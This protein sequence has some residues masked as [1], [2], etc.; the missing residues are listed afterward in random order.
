ME[1]N[2]YSELQFALD[3]PLYS[4]A[5]EVVI[6]TNRA[7]IAGLQRRLTIGYNRA[8]RFIEAMQEEGV[9]SRPNHKGDRSVLATSANLKEPQSP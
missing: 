7:S 2:D 3:D 5:K 8:A 4:T 6:A 9:V 1:R